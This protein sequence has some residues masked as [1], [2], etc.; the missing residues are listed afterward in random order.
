MSCGASFN[1]LQQSLQRH[2]KS[3]SFM[4]KS[5]IFFFS[6]FSW[7]IGRFSN[8]RPEF[9]TSTKLPELSDTAWT[10]VIQ[11]KTVSSMTHLE[12][13]ACSY[14]FSILP[15]FPW[16]SSTSTPPWTIPMLN[17]YPHT[18][19]QVGTNSMVTLTFLVGYTLQNKQTWLC[20]FPW[21]GDLN[22]PWR[23]WCWR[24]WIDWRN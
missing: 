13:A 12:N 14:H 15:S 19:K 17:K 24:R 2:L 23:L 11:I 7:D 18:L 21:T 5:Q 1:C 4:K 3:E 20:F 10:Y 6:Q 22:S 16:E 9:P 8:T